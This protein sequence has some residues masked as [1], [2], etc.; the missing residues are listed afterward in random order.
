MIANIIDKLQSNEF[1]NCSE[2]IELAKGKNE[3]VS[4][5][6]DAK[7]KIKRTWRLRKQ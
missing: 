6:K 7:R 2:S 4:N 1:Y 5:F 3:L